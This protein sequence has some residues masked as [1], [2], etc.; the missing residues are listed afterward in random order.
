MQSRIELEQQSIETSDTSE[1]VSLITYVQSLKCKMK[2]WEKQVQ[3]YKEGQRILERQRFQFPTAWLYSD[4]V[5]GE[6]GAFSDIIRRKDSSIQ[7][8]V[9]SLQMKVISEDKVVE[10][11][12]NDLLAEWEKD[13]PVEVGWHFIILLLYLKLFSFFFPIPE[14]KCLLLSTIITNVNKYINFILIHLI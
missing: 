14:G 7:T 1:A 10:S 12:T 11:R 8:Q 2:N 13:K 9:A 4:N 6:W 5:E 3:L